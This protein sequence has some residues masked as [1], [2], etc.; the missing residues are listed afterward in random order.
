[1]KIFTRSSFKITSTVNLVVKIYIPSSVVRGVYSV[2]YIS[3]NLGDIVCWL[4][5][6]SAAL[7]LPEP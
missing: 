7:S 6:L 5:E 4:A 1:M 3:L 2:P